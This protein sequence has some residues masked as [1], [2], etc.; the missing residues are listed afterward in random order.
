MLAMAALPGKAATIFKE[1]GG[2][3]VMEAE[4]FDS[5]TTS[6]D[7]HKYTIISD[8]AVLGQPG[9]TPAY[10]NARGS[11]LVPLPDTVGGGVNNNGADGQNVG[12]SVDY[13]VNIATTGEYRLWL[14]WGG[15][16]GSSD[17]MYAQIVENT[18]SPLW[19]RYSR[20][21]NGDFASDWLGIAGAETNDG[22]PDATDAAAVWTISTPGIY[23]IRLSMREDGSGTDALL[24]QLSSLADP[25]PAASGSGPAESDLSEGIIANA[26][27]DVAAVPPATATLNA[28]VKT[29]PGAAVT[30]QWQSAPSGS[31]VFSDIAGATS[32]SYTTPA[33]TLAMNGT[34]YRYNA[35]SSGTTVTSGAATLTTD[36][37]PP[38]ISYAFSPTATTLRIAF[39]E[40]V[41]ATSATTVGNY[42]LAPGLT[43]S[44]PTLSADGK[45]VTLTTTAQTPGTPYTLT[46]NGVKDV[47]GNTLNN[48][49]ASFVGPT[50]LTVS[51]TIEQR[52]W[53][54]IN[55]N[56]VS[57]LKADPRYPAN[58]TA[59]TFEPLF[60][61]PPNAGG[62][63]GDTYGNR[64]SGWI[65]APEDGDYVFF[66]CSDDPSELYLSTDAD[67]SNKKLIARET[68]WS[69]ARQ[70]VSS[71]GPSDLT[72]KRSDQFTGTAWPTRDTV[73]GGARITLQKDQHYYIEVLHTEGGG[74]DNVGVNWILP[75]AAG[76]D[77]TDGDPP[78]SADYVD[79]IYALNGAVKI[80][81]QPLSQSKG[82][83]SSATFTIAA[84]S[85]DNSG[86]TYVWQ[87][88]PAG[89]STFTGNGAVGTSFT[90]P[91]LTTAD[92]GTQYRVLVLGASGAAI[93]SVATL[94]VTV[95]NVPPSVVYFGGMR[96]AA[97]IVFD[98]PIDTASAETVANYSIGPS[99]SVTAATASTAPSGVGV[100]TITL[101]GVTNFGN[102]TVTIKNVKDTANNAMV[103]TTK[104]FTAYDIYSDFNGTVPPPKGTLIGSA[105]VLAGG[106]PD[107]SGVLELTTNVGSLQGTL[108][109]DDV[110]GGDA[111]NVTVKLKLFIGLGND[112][113]DGVS[114]NIAGDIDA[115]TV[116]AG[117]EGTGTGL[118]IN[119]DTYDNGPVG[120]P[121][122]APAVEVKWNGSIVTMPDGNLA[123]IL[124]PKPTLVNNQWVDVFIQLLGDPV[125]GTGTV[126]V[127]H[128]NVKYFD[129]LPIDG[130][131]N[132]SNPKVAI[133]GRT[134]GVVERAWVDNLLV[135]YNDLIPAP[136]PPTISITAPANGATLTAGSSATITVNVTADAGVNKVEFFA[137]GQSLGSSTTAPYSFT[138]PQ[139]PPGFYSLTA[140]VTDQNGVLV[141]SSPVNVTVRPP[142]SANAPK[143]LFVH[144]SGGPNASDSAMVNHLFAR[145]FDVY[146]IGAATSTTDDATGKA[147]VVVSS[148]VTSGDVGDKFR[149]AAT[150][151]FNWENALQDNFQ[152]V[153]DTATDHSTV[154]ARTDLVIDDPT[155]PLAAGLSG[156]VVVT[157]NAQ[158]QSWA[159]STSLPV[160]TLKVASTTEGASHQAIYGIEKGTTL[161]DG[162]AAAA[163]RAHVFMTD[164]SFANL[165]ADGLKLVDAAVTWLTT[166]PGGGP[167]AAKLT[168]SVSGSNLTIAWT[169]GGTLE[170]TS[171]LLPGAV[172]T[173]TNDTDG[174][175]TEAINTAQNKFFRVRNP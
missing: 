94:T 54:N 143:V 48:G 116:S 153:P 123:Q 99:G 32:A 106:G 65:L 155:S 111:T 98:E 115:T 119:F 112:G 135:I 9:A 174:S 152:F 35:T 96:T 42:T 85:V 17:S 128:N 19:Y 52:F 63:A 50:I 173:S 103:Q 14:R 154:V 69:N 41:N 83:N 172:W 21:I 33:T 110:L 68:V 108:G 162:T 46:V 73:N 74:G 64:M 160:G 3:V 113:A 78:I 122:E 118:S 86:L 72:A 171:A 57:T 102:Y 45:I 165:T 130:F 40:A 5:R 75:S 151:V 67:P 157:S 159:L 138:V 97:Q 18:A 4:H 10:K 95:D 47:A 105:K 161:L 145:G 60:E 36:A 93:S 7:G 44:N 56:T 149:A 70:W 164:N 28:A 114:I 120:G 133:G 167:Q 37:T 61:Y 30:Y 131:A 168:A 8:E 13:K 24:F 53:N 125:A 148:T 147:L 82:A 77:P 39:S 31:T 23:T 175:Y 92:S 84:N 51:K 136:K 109:I 62:E 11:Y 66:T 76:V 43:A 170:W 104:T 26:P 129:N 91:L 169:N 166:A 158:D 144:S 142:A 15:Y 27:A 1:V 88:A 146:P 127:I 79:Q 121:A 87:T 100:V 16:D 90:T 137:N 58:P 38:S 101:T 126:T 29:G 2:V 139:A 156:T 163:R 34:K 140:T 22:G 59:I 134:G 80:T 117:E 124:V 71:A 150:P 49:T 25:P 20:N 107:N 55:N 6:A 81:T 89:S 132:I 12:P 141:T